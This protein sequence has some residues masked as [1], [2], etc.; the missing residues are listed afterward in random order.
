[1]KTAVKLLLPL[2]LS[3]FFV[4]GYAQTENQQNS[5]SINF[6]KLGNVVPGKLIFKNGDILEKKIKYDNPEDL[7]K[8]EGEIY[9]DEPSQMAFGSAYKDRL[10]SFEIDGHVWKRITHKGDEQFG[11]VHVDGAVQYYS[12]FRIP[13]ARVTGDYQEQSYV[14]KLDEEPISE[15]VFMLKYKKTMLSL[16]SDNEDIKTKIEN[17][18]K[19]YKNFLTFKKVAKEYNDWYSANHPE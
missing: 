18:E 6:S 2:I 11:I 15:G 5:Q 1:M 14:R 7:K 16:M 12:V 19:G 9:Y 8:L 4:R 13:M 10:E 17:K 3:I